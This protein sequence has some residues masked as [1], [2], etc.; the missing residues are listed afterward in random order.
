M[1]A[2]KKERALCFLLSEQLLTRPDYPEIGLIAIEIRFLPHK[3]FKSNKY[4]LR[5]ELDQRTLKT[6]E[7][8]SDQLA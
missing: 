4:D 5:P 8:F 1:V 3:V 2:A 6:D 7:N